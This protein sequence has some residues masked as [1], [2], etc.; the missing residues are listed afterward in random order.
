MKIDHQYHEVQLRR[1]IMDLMKLS[2]EDWSWISWSWVMRIHHGS[3][4]VLSRELIIDIMNL[5]YEDWSSLSWSWVIRI[6]HGCHEVSYEDWSWISWGWVMRSCVLSL[7][8]SCF[9]DSF[10]RSIINPH[11]TTLWDPWWIHITQFHE[12]HD[13]SPWFNFIGSMINPYN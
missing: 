10:M 4:E 6:H 7:M 5:S 9:E 8:K 3:L 11:N 2:Y 1:L 12:I 13:Q